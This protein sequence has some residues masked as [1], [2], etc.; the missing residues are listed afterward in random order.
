MKPPL[1][2]AKS[3]AQSA[4]SNPLPFAPCS[5]PGHKLHL[6][7]H[8]CKKNPSNHEAVLG[9]ELTVRETA[10]QSS[11]RLMPTGVDY[12]R[13]SVLTL[14]VE[15]VKVMKRRV[16]GLVVRVIALRAGYARSPQTSDGY[17]HDAPCCVVE[18]DTPGFGGITSSLPASVGRCVPSSHRAW[19][20][21]KP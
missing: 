20:T 21:S 2:N 8:G 1:E 17:W 16:F 12:A 4:R 11:S 5:Q 13:S 15:E 6:E 14:S 9:E 7:V 18:M 19:L 3:K 10:G